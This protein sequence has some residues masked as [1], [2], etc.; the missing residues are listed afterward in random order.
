MASQIRGSGGAETGRLLFAG[1]SGPSW[2][3]LRTEA[4]A[5]PTGTAIEENKRYKFILP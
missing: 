1:A 3:A 5:T 4:I 2:E